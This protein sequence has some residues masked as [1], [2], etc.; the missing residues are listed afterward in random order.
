M[1]IN[2]YPINID[3]DQFQISRISYSEELLKELRNKYNKTHSFFRDSDFIY[4]SN[5]SNDNIEIG[6]IVTLKV[7]DSEKVT[8]SLIKHIFFRTFRERFPDIKATSFY[9][10]RFFSRVSTDDLVQIYLPE[11]LKGLI[12]YKKQIE[13]QLRLLNINSQQKQFGFIVN[14]SYQWGITKKC[15][16]LF[17]EGFE[18]L[19]TE[20]LRIEQMPES[21][22]VLAPNEEFIGEVKEIVDSNAIII[23]NDGEISI[24]LNELTLRRSTYNIKSYLTFLL[25]ESQSEAIV[26][27][28]K[29]DEHGRLNNQKERTEITKIAELIALY[30]DKSHVIYQ[31]KDGFYFN[32][33]PYPLSIDNSFL[34]KNPPFIFDHAATK[35]ENK[36]ADIGLNNFGP[37]DSITFDCKSPHIIGICAKRNRGSF[38]SF[39]AKLINGDPTSQWFKKGF[40]KK[41][42]LN[43]VTYEVFDI[44]N[45]DFPGYENIISQIG[46]KPDLIIMEIPESFKKLRIEDNPYYK[47]KAKLLTLEIPF[48]F[49]I[50]SKVRYH[51]DALLNTM[52]LQIYA[53]LGG[54][55]WVLPS[56]CSIDRELIIGIGNSIIRNNNYKG[57]EKN[58]VVGITTFFSSDGQ[59]LL[60]NKA[61][62]VPY[63]DYFNELLRTLKE[64]FD[65]LKD[66][67]GWKDND[68]IRLIFHIF[69]PIKNTEFDVICNL[70]ECYP[71]YKI[72]FAFVTIS[73]KHPFKLYEPAQQG[74]TK[75]SK[76]LG[77]YTPLRG[78]NIILDSTSCLI[79]MLGAN[80]IKTDRHGA[81]SPILVR[82][83]IPQGNYDNV[84]LNDML[85]TDIQ[86]ISQQI[87]SFTYLSWRSFLP[88][89][90][91][92]T[93]LYSDLI[94]NL[95]GR[96]R[97]IQGWQP[98]V[99]NFKL[100]QKKWFL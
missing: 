95:L 99:L 72:Q 98:D 2:F 84:K 40:Q 61:K 4:I 54:T 38:T 74:I 27:K 93:M 86:Y 89:E 90:L 34:L 97:K 9:P 79:Q 31:N 30:K 13:L 39:L 92:A 46:N 96:L 87:F 5:N 57:A 3:F 16:D 80:E 10:F 49:V 85:F 14:T 88:K 7:L 11:R 35:V 64:A 17:S 33:S 58:R 71:E 62:D 77:E 41:Y 78:S 69:K 1:E 76:T 52:G 26:S 82:I 21:K 65:H 67:Q 8:S 68:T 18:L 32:I 53:K 60:S 83:R 42:D 47:L 56:T 70:I 19:G 43:N 36:N 75:G 59:Y 63:S 23:S 51:N 81:S 25:D 15:S 29:H 94:A 20:I 24:P 37:W 12:T 91:P 66:I 48:Q 100:K 22:D 6:D 73:K 45:C 55:P 50:D 28:A 44:P